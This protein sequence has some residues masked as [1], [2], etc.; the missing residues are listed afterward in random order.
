MKLKDLIEQYGEYEVIDETKFKTWDAKL[1]KERSGSVQIEGR[2]GIQIR[3]EP[4]KPKSVWDLKSEDECWTLD[5]TGGITHERYGDGFF[6]DERRE[7]G[8][9]F[10]TEKETLKEMERRKIE[11]LLLK[12][13]GRRWYKKFG[14]NF[15]FLI[16]DVD[17]FGIHSLNQIQ[18][19][20]Y[21]DTYSDAKTALDSIG[22]DRIKK[23]LFEVR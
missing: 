7:F 6:N 10:L 1:P 21:F 9:V 23:A 17:R 12:H 18:G 19:T 13:G 14:E 2:E 5:E 8:N 16:D 15:G 22:A 3:L 20:I 11:T 4:P